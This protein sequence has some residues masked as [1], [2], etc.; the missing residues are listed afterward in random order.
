MNPCVVLKIILAYRNE[1]VIDV[2]F[3]KEEATNQ[4]MVVFKMSE[5]QF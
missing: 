1:F 3:I 2:I 5:K 4:L